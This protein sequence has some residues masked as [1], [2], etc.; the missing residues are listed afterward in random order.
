MHGP[1]TVAGSLCLQAIADLGGELFATTLLVVVAVSQ[2]PTSRY[3]CTL[4]GGLHEARMRPSGPTS[5][6]VS[7]M[8][9]DNGNPSALQGA[10]V[11][12]IVA[13]ACSWFGV[14]LNPHFLGLNL[15]FVWL[16]LAMMAWLLL[17]LSAAAKQ[18][19]HRGGLPLSMILY[20]AFTA[21]Y[22]FDYFWFEENITSTWDMIAER[23]GFMLIFGDMVWIPFTFSM[24]AW[25]LLAHPVELSPMSAA[26]ITTMFIVGFTVF[27]G[28][29]NQKHKF[30][31]NPMAL[32][33]GRPPRVIDGKLLAS[34]YWGIARHCNYLGDLILALSY[35]LPCGPSSLV[36][37]LY[38]A[39]L[40]VLLVWRER[41]DEARCRQ[42]YGET[43]KKYCSA[44]PWRIVPLIY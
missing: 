21:I 42:K 1:T 30:K 36:P 16:R 40:L 22:I 38:P 13:L 44:V 6:P 19:Q 15:K 8:T 2:P 39:Y 4:V 28:A 31:Q 12:L 20:Q 3:S 26:S 29:N 18:L 5:P 41:R 33:W 14:Q 37:Y 9:S 34:G 32:I 43:W 7:C 17:N 25:W 11:A 35:S 23:F 27:R 10:V 24:Q